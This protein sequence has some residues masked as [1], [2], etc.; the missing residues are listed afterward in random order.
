MKRI[1]M[2]LSS[3]VLAGCITLGPVPE[4]ELAKVKNIGVVSLL[5]NTLHAIHIGFTVFNNEYYS[6]QVEDWQIDTFTSERVVKNLEQLKYSVGLVNLGSIPVEDFY[7]NKRFDEVD[8]KRLLTI[9]DNQGYDT[10]VLVRRV[11]HDSWRFHR[12]GYGFYQRKVFGRGYR[13]LYNILVVEVHNV[14]AQ[15][16]LAFQW[17][18]PCETGDEDI[19]WKEKFDLYSIK[20]K[21][22]MKMK[23][24]KRIEENINSAIE[25][26]RFVVPKR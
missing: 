14:R 20:E 15:K 25:G 12:S 17:G 3:L 24:E 13:C 6:A 26:L 11:R 10:V 23:L 9:A 7:I 5:G 16:K 1:L 22:T 19:E 18:Y 21:Q 8:Y 4:E 2:A